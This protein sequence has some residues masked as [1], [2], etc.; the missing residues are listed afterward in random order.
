MRSSR[1]TNSSFGSRRTNGLSKRAVH[2][3]KAQLAELCCPHI[4]L[5]TSG[6]NESITRFFKYSHSID[7][8]S[9]R[10]R[11]RRSKQS[12]TR[13]GLTHSRH[14]RVCQS[15]TRRRD[16]MIIAKKEPDINAQNQINL[17]DSICCTEKKRKIPRT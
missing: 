6:N 8:R 17:S 13:Y 3:G 4:Q 5:R 16:A 12:E 11:L 1:S 7:P 15:I 14:S 2:V 10:H 9:I